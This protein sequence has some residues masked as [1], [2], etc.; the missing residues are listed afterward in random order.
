LA[1]QIFSASIKKKNNSNY[2]SAIWDYSWYNKK[3]ILHFNKLPLQSL[4][5][6]DA[7]LQLST[8]ILRK[9]FD[10]VLYIIQ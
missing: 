8:L 5:G 9:Q 10:K 2:L 7:L 4:A 1:I 3:I 6:A